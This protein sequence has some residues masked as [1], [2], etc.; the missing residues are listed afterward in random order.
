MRDAPVLHLFGGKGGAGKTALASAFALTLS[1]ANPRGKRPPR[2]L[3]GH[4]RPLRR[5][6]EEAGREAHPAGAG[7][8]RGRAVGDWSS[9]CHGQTKVDAV[10]AALAAAGPP[11]GLL[12]GERMWASWS[13]AWCR[14]RA[15]LRAA[16]GGA[17]IEPGK[18]DRLVVDMA[19]TGPTLGCSTPPPCSGERSPWCGARS[20]A[21]KK[22][23]TR[24]LATPR[25]TSWWRSWTA[26]GRC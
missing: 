8:G 4:P 12:L 10:R 18:L 2:H 16:G 24:R 13:R 14:A 22:Q 7:Q 1:D 6:A 26:S 9:S 20:P 3:G 11:K 21:A 17:Q 15:A 19:G 5:L 23:R 25:S